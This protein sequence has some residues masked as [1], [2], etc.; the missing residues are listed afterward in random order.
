MKP[1]GVSRE[2]EE[3][4]ELAAWR[5]LLARSQQDDVDESKSDSE[6]GRF[7]SLRAELAEELSIEAIDDFTPSQRQLG[8]Y[9]IL[10][11]VGR[12][13]MGIVYEAEQLSFARRVALKVLPEGEWVTICRCGQSENK[14][15]C[16][17]AHRGA[18]FEAASKAG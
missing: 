1:D 10:R 9:L 5:E 3:T 14:P 12:G 11:Q 13:G 18:G 2:S 15:F 17:G 8:D 6:S 16:D 4:A 7:S